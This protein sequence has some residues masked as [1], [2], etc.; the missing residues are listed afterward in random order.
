MI[1][2]R[3][4]AIRIARQLLSQNPVYLDTETTGVERNSEIVEICVLDDD[5]KILLE[6]LVKPGGKIPPDATRIH[7]ITS[8]MLVD[9]PAWPE[10]WL[11]TQSVLANRAVGIYNAE[12]D[13][14][15]MKQSH[16]RNFM[17]WPSQPGFST[18]CLMKLYAQFKGDW[19]SQRGSYRWHSLETAR[20]HCK[21][22]LP[23]SHRAQADCRLARA[24]LHY[25][26]D[27]Q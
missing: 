10:V 14:R 1:A 27:S 3:M 15:L 20:M 19:N 13:I 24:V 16:E 8:V 6:T 23:N 12:F 5:E 2:S 11:Q 17:R 9:A 26:A 4:E 22:S 25:M 21:I 7:G 18:I